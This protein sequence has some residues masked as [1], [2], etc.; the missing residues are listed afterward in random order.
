MIAP[1]SLLLRICIETCL[2][3]ASAMCFG[4]CFIRHR[5]W[6]IRNKCL[7]IRLWL[8]CPLSTTVCWIHTATI[9]HV[10]LYGVVVSSQQ[11]ILPSSSSLRRSTHSSSFPTASLASSLQRRRILLSYPLSFQPLCSYLWSHSY[12]GFVRTWAVSWEA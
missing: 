8:F 11:S 4:N 10:F 6:T 7:E 9:L 2:R 12:V 5:A 1:N 3:V